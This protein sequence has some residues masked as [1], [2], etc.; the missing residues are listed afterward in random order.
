MWFI[1]SQSTKRLYVKNENR[2]HPLQTMIKT[3]WEGLRTP[4]TNFDIFRTV[5]LRII[6]VDNQLDAQIFYNTAIYLNPLHVSSTSVL[7]L[8]R[9]T[10]GII[11][12]C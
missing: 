3:L 7:I 11:T 8:R 12:L 6:L 5:H 4:V 2:A 10:S 1:L 9:T